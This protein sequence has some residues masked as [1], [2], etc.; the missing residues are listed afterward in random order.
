MSGDE[1]SSYD[2]A[3]LSARISAIADVLSRLLAYEAR[4]QDHPEAFLSDI[5]RAMETQLQK[6][7]ENEPLD[8]DAMTIQEVMQNEVDELV[9]IAR[10]HINHKPGSPDRGT[11]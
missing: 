10:R 11:V 2:P 1:L 7:V 8:R 6:A 5:S 3:V 9:G 4:R